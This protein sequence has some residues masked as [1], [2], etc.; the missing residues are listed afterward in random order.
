M[1]PIKYEGGAAWGGGEGG[2][3]L[4]KWHIILLVLSGNC[5]RC[6]IWGAVTERNL[7]G[8]P[9]SGGGQPRRRRSW[10]SCCVRHSRRKTFIRPCFK[11]RSTVAWMRSRRSKLEIFQ[12]NSVI[13]LAEPVFQIKNWSIKFRYDV[14]KQWFVFLSF[15]SFKHYKKILSVHYTA[16]TTRQ[17]SG[18]LWVSCCKCLCRET[19]QLRAF[20]R[21][22]LVW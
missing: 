1:G 14:L 6:I 2:G 4:W 9:R 22:V 12:G 13:Y 5:R 15:W 18:A 10:C 8:V 7:G 3:N 17:T 19:Q 16:H 11:L 20:S 21:D